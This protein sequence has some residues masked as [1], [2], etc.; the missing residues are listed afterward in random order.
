LSGGVGLWFNLAKAPFND[1]QARRAVALAISPTAANQTTFNG[2]D[3]LATTWMTE[4]SKYYDKS[5]KLPT[6]PSTGT[7]AEAQK[8]LDQLAA[9]KGGPLKFT[10][11]T[12]TIASTLSNS[13]SLQTQLAAYK[14]ISVDLEVLDPAAFPPRLFAGTWDAIMAGSS[15]SPE[16]GIYEAFHTG[17]ANNWG[18][19]SDPAVDQA[20][21]QSRAAG[22]DAARKAAYKT[23]QQHLIDQVPIVFL[24]HLVFGVASEKKLT[25]F[26]L[27]GQGT[28]LWDRIGYTASQKK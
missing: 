16:P 26:Q 18:K 28:L 23:V 9:A 6:N 27:W 7:N 8:L 2:V 17:G 12:Q 10:I 25:G 11:V 22:D 24:Q 15:G 3:P 14:N 20:L 19:Y 13:K 21:E 4:E 5:L 1:L